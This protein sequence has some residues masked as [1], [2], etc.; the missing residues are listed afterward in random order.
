MEAST[1]VDH[2]RHVRDFSD[3]LKGIVTKENLEQQ[4]HEYQMELGF[5]STRELVGIFRKE[6]DVRVFWR[7][8][9]TNSKNEYVAFLHLVENDGHVEVVNV[10]VS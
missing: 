3:R 1:E 9:Y 7:Q 5:F 6:N 8:W 10:S 4:C 2:E